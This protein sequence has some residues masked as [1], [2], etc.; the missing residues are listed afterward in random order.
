MTQIKQNLPVVLKK[1]LLWKLAA[2][3]YK[4]I[5]STCLKWEQL[6]DTVSLVVAQYTCF[7]SDHTLCSFDKPVFGFFEIP[8]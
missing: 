2:S 6:K 3:T 7:H 5:H 8:D 1:N 4:S